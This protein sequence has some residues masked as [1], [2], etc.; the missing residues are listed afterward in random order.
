MKRTRSL[1]WMRQ[2]SRI[3][4]YVYF[5]AVPLVCFDALHTH[6]Q[7]SKWSVHVWTNTY[8]YKRHCKYKQ[9]THLPHTHFAYTSLWQRSF[10][11]LLRANVLRR[12]Q[13]T[14]CRVFFLYLFRLCVWCCIWFMFQFFCIHCA[15]FFVHRSLNDDAA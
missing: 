1:Y 7:I 13:L 12:F 2:C 3:V 10:I 11:Y 9:Y 6:T 8:S 5:I 15:Q 14:Y 4:L